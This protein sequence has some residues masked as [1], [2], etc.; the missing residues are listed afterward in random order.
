MRKFCPRCKVEKLLSDF[1][2][3]NRSSDGKYCYC[4]QCKNEY[5]KNLYAT[6][7]TLAGKIKK[8]QY[9]HHLQS[10]R[11]VR[12]YLLQHPCVDCGE[13]D[14]IVLEFDHIEPANK[15]FEISKGLGSGFSPA[16]LEPEIA[17]CDIRCANCHKRR[18]AKQQN[19]YVT[20]D[21]YTLS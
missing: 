10:R 12:A 13:T 7:P 9:N 2:K 18:T 14:P 4:R 17:K 5:N 20:L 16:R 1:T 6:S 15:S 8:N 11:Y 19:W 21:G 3:D